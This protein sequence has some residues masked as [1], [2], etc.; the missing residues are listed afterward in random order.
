ML[1]VAGA[2]V[3]GVALGV[4]ALPGDST[5]K[6]SGPPEIRYNEHSCATCGMVITDVRFAAASRSETGKVQRY[7]D[8]GCMIAM[9]RREGGTGTGTYYVHDYTDE[10]WVE[11]PSAAFVLADK[12]KTPM[13]YGL[14]ALATDSAA[15]T[16]ASEH[17]G[18]IVTW[19]QAVAEVEAGGSM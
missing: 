7:D 1:G 16:L 12:I 2:T 9:V 8:I 13:A 5:D 17:G 10:S 14:V 15:Q 3:G 11:A 19:E 4:A 18:R 6:G